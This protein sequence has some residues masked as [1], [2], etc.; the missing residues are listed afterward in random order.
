MSINKR[1]HAVSEYI[2]HHLDAPLNLQQ[3]ASQ[4]H[5][6]PY[7]FHRLFRASIGMS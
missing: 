1:L 6:S 5:L 4:A 3:L 7:H 2:G